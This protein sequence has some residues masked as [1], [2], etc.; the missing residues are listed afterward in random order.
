MQQFLLAEQW[1]GNLSWLND[2]YKTLP[3]ILYAI[4]AIV[5]GAGV[6][7]SIVLGV[8]LAKSENDEKRKYAAYRLRNTL[9]GVAVLLVLVL[10]INIGLPALLKAVYGDKGWGDPNKQQSTAQMLKTTWNLLTIR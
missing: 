5:G 2:V 6:V 9:I 8:N 4:L 1:L 7:Y 3:E 10:L